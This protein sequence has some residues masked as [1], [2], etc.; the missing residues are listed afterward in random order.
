LGDPFSLPKGIDFAPYIDVYTNY[1]F[2]N[3]FK[4]SLWIAGLSTLIALFIYSCAGYIFGKFEFRGK[5]FLY[6]LCTVTLLVPGH[7]KAQPIFSLIMELGL[8]DT[9]T[10]LILVYTSFGLAL[11]LFVLRATFM[12][13]PKDLD[14]AALIDG[15]SFWR[16]FWSVNLPLARSGIATAGILMFLGNWNEYFYAL[17]LT[18]SEVN[19][20]LPVALQFFDE[21]FSYNYTRMFAALTLVIT[22]GILIYLLVQEQVQASVAS[23]GVKG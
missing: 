7:A 12:T 8:Y 9:K 22:P 11:A 17:I 19:R 10:G 2:L 20:T 1:N 6:V 3:F 14:E 4:N 23:T 21:A 15:A 16:I 18:T 5:T 13:I